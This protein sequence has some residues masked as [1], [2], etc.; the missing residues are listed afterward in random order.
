MMRLMLIFLATFILLVLVGL[1]VATVF[2]EAFSEGADAYKA[3]LTDPYAIQAIR[4]TLL[5]ALI[6]VPANLI[7]GLAISWLVCKY[8]FRG[9]SI[10]SSLIDLPFSVSPV[11]A[12][13]I[14]VLLYGSHSLIGGWL[15]EH[16][17]EIIFAVPGIVLATMFVT[18]P[19]VARELIPLMRELGSEQE[20]AAQM[21]GARGWQIFWRV[22]LPNIRLGVLYGVL[23]STAR[24]MGEFGAVAVV[25]GHIRGETT[26]IPLQVEILY[27]EYNFMAAFA[28]ASVLTLLAFVTLI[29]KRVIEARMHKATREAA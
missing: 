14:Y 20:E 6:A 7:F 9:K 23:L 18:F 25:S 24:A 19:Y 12:G 28:V 4:L 15:E 17:I 13:L 21:L 22:S 26:T 8:E 5:V 16:G 10:L 1:P 11:I 29:L 3:A 27:N 2:H